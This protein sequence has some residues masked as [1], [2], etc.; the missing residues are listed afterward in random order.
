MTEHRYYIQEPILSIQS[1]SQDRRD[2]VYVPA[3]TVVSVPDY[4]PDAKFVEIVW[5]S[6][7]LL[8]FS[9]DLQDRAEPYYY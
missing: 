2:F 9:Q 7:T 3:G 1:Q 6:K 4:S 5:D 8:M